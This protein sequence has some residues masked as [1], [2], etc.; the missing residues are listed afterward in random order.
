MYLLTKNLKTIRPSQ[1]LDYKKIGFF[2]IKKTKGEYQLQIGFPKK[3]KIYP[4]F[5]ISLLEP[6]NQ[7][8][9]I[10]IKLS[11]LSSENKYKIKKIINYDYKNQ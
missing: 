4:I 6:V 2:F 5:Y 9:P 1:K 7:K 3:I 10:F 8:F 11:K